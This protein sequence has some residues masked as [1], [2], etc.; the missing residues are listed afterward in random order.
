[1]SL[2][3]CRRVQETFQK[4]LPALGEGKREKKIIV[5]GLWGG[6]STDSQQTC[7]PVGC[8]RT[9]RCSGTT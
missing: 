7:W 2:E 4:P 5:L 1:M 9:T 3:R 6:G 8:S